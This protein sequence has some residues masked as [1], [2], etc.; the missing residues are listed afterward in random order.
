MF[1]VS[2]FNLNNSSSVLG[3]FISV[4]YINPMKPL[5]QEFD[6]CHSSVYLVDATDARCIQHSWWCA[7]KKLDRTIVGLHT[8]DSKC[9]TSSE[10]YASS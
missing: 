4:R 7:E 6:Y 2:K 5:P 9:C 8:A 1:S 3:M 10:R